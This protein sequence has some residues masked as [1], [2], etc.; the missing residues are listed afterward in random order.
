MKRIWRELSDQH[1][2]SISRATVGRPKSATHRQHISQGMKEYWK[3]VPNKPEAESGSTT[4][5]DLI[6]A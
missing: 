4:M 2:E 1:R 6:G 5:N 3:T